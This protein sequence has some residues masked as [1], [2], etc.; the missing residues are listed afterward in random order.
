[1]YARVI[2][3]HYQPDKIEEALHILRETVIPELQQLPGFKG[4][5]NLVDYGH[6]KVVGMTLWDSKDN[7]QGSGM[8]KL[9]ARFAKISAYLAAMPTVEVY[10]V[11]D[12][13]RY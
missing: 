11:S 8:N 10:E 9:Q 3:F 7:L 1:M 6:D 12:E 13:Q 5:T 2:T 4:A